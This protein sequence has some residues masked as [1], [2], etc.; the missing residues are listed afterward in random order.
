VT[1]PV[2]EVKDLEKHYHGE[3]G[4]AVRAV[5]GVSL[6]VQPREIFGIVGESGSGKSTLARLVL[7]LT[8]PTAG[9]ISFCG[10]RIDGMPER[11]FRARRRDIQIVLQDPLAA[12]DPRWKLA[13]SVREFLGL[14][15]DLGRTATRAELDAAAESV[16]LHPSVLGR[17][18]AQVSGGQ[19]QRLSVARALVTNPK[20]LV[21]D[22]PTSSLDV[23]IRGQIVNLLL[24]QREARGLA[25][26]LISHDLD[27]VRA[28]A[29]RVAV[30]YL[31]QVVEI[32]PVD[33]V[34]GRPAHPYT[35]GLLDATLFITGE[36]TRTSVRLQGE[37]HAGDEEYA[38]C[39]LVSRCPFAEAKCREPQELLPVKG[40]QSVRCWKA[41][42]LPP[43]QQ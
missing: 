27:V 3:D 40:G 13:R 30:M 34:L 23:S 17:Y 39:R 42:A 35:Q 33:A 12:F 29:D 10:E 25:L 16:G 8:P 41:D 6:D 7:K 31:G 11:H 43:R 22:E 14:R 37:L 38:G 15:S 26:V 20:L 1:E 18:P 4:G 36:R 9:E 2:L 19:L 24:E 21:V 28:M 5:D 32:G